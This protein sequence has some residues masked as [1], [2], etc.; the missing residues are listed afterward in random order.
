MWEYW[1]HK[2]TKDKRSSSIN[3][4]QDGLPS[5]SAPVGAPPGRHPCPRSRVLLYELR[6]PSFV[7]A[8][9]L[10]MQLLRCI[11]CFPCQA[12]RR[13]RAP[14]ALWAGWA[15]G[16][17][18]ARAGCSCL[19]RCCAVTPHKPNPAPSPRPHT[20]L[21]HL[22]RVLQSGWAFRSC[23]P[24]SR[25][26]LT[27]RRRRCAP[28]P[29]PRTSTSRQ[30]WAPC[31]HLLLEAPALR[32]TA[33]LGCLVPMDHASACLPG[34]TCTLARLP[35]CLIA[36]FVPMNSSPALTCRAGLEAAGPR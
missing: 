6:A 33:C 5:P 12:Q 36:C 17:A 28:T 24:R 23:Q 32:C 4:R 21:N 26:I 30:G 11:Y 14:C 9:A 29:P 10:Q 25:S 16:R 2:L 31:F 13:H 3:L 22:V 1:R 8:A 19:H 18:G 7:W 27:R 15:Q 34:A 20:H 35:T